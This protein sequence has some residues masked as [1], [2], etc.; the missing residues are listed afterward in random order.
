MV[1]SVSGVVAAGIVVIILYRNGYVRFWSSLACILFGFFLAGT[2]AAPSVTH[3]LTGC[4]SVISNI[5]RTLS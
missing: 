3:F 5:C 2:A 4:G 1:L